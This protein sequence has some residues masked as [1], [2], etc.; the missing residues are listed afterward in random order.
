M[1]NNVPYFMTVDN[2]IIDRVFFAGYFF[3]T[4][5]YRGIFKICVVIFKKIFMLSTKYIL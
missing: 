5:I 3:H 2:Q 4:R 1:T